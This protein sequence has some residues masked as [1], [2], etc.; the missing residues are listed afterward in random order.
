M[1]FLE[2]LTDDKHKNQNHNLPELWT[3]CNSP[4][5]RVIAEDESNPENGCIRHF[6]EK[7]W[8]YVDDVDGFAIKHE[9]ELAS[10]DIAIVE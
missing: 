3:D 8:I 7:F 5:Y 2:I 10:L 4:I 1:T 9:S 6:V